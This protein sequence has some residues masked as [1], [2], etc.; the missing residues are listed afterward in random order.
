MPFWG[1]PSLLVTFSL[2]LYS[3][4]L[5][6]VFLSYNFLFEGFHFFLYLITS[7][8]FSLLVSFLF[9]SL[10]LFWC[11]LF[12]MPPSLS[13][14]LLF[15]DLFFFLYHFQCLVLFW[16]LFFLWV[17]FFWCFYFIWCSHLL[18]PPSFEAT[19]SFSNFFLLVSLSLSR[20]IFLFVLLHVCF[21][22]L[23]WWYF[24]LKCFLHFWCLL[25]HL[26]WNFFFFWCTFPFGAS[27]SFGALSHWES[28]SLLIPR[29]YFGTIST[30]LTQ[31]CYF[32]ISQRILI[33]LVIFVWHKFPR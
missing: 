19:F 32:D 4:L 5:G 29:C 23:F 30:C 12:C 2:I 8:V 9:E 25:P 15:W 17:S 26:F 11:P 24:F 14:S 13:M 3:S 7:D 22:L 20:C 18:I 28:P 31:P 21:I 16:C 27:F 1:F 10:L 33:L 6:F